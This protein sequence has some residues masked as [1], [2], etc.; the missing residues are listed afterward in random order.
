V[1]VTGSIRLSS[2]FLT[3]PTRGVPGQAIISSVGATAFRAEWIAVA[4]CPS[5][6]AKDLLGFLI[7]HARDR[8]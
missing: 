4:A 6:L 8:R 2:L 7:A 3:L 5:D 1:T